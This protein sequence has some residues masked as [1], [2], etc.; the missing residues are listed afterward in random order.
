MFMLGAGESSAPM[1]SRMVDLQLSPGPTM[2]FRPGAGRH[3]SISMPR[4]PSIL[5]NRIEG[6][7]PTVITSS[8]CWSIG[9]VRIM[10]ASL[11]TVTLSAS[12]H[13]STDK[14][15]ALHFDQERLHRV[16][17]VLTPAGRT[18]AE[19][20]PLRWT[21]VAENVDRSEAEPGQTRFARFETK[22]VQRPKFGTSP[23]SVVQ[24]ARL[25][26]FE[27]WKKS[28]AQGASLK[29]RNRKMAEGEGLTSNLLWV[30]EPFYNFP[31]KSGCRASL[32][33]G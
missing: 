31:R 28:G 16:L 8:A 3:L 23:V 22:A 1:A 14:R 6:F 26:A 27:T 9:S 20:A 24:V 12:R 15:V 18:A 7:G 30:G 21:E 19:C 29:V 13:S 32:S 10:V 11:K 5:R 17:R 25:N 4:N 2:T 33:P